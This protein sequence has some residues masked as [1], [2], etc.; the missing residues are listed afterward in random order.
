MTDI[1]SACFSFSN[2]IH[3]YENVDCAVLYLLNRFLW[4]LFICFSRF[5]FFPS[6]SF[7]IFWWPWQ[8]SSDFLK[9][10]YISEAF[11]VWNW[12]RVTDWGAGIEY[13]LT[14][15][16]EMSQNVQFQD[17][18]NKKPKKYAYILCE[19]PQIW[20]IFQRYHHFYTCT[21]FYFFRTHCGI[22]SRRQL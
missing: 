16:I 11:G 15:S 3:M 1:S 5:V 19:L 6:S 17:R 21:F 20:N 12:M 9:L 22:I 10:F 14:V 8:M 7:H 4:S 18:L 2:H 13:N